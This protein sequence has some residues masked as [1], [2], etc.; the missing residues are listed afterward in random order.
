[1]LSMPLKM[2]IY[3]QNKCTI[4]S[5]YTD[6]SFLSCF[7][8]GFGCAVWHV[9]LGAKSS[10]LC[11]TLYDLMDCSALGSSVK[12]TGVG[13]H[14]PL[15]GIFLNQGSNTHLL[16]WQ[17]GSLPLAPPG[18]PSKAC[19]VLILPPGIE[20]MPPEL[21]V[22]SLNHWTTREVPPQASF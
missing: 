18:K 12:N 16:H 13:C 9:C 14:A 6:K 1:M 22:W 2:C 11:L 20:P 8:F 10:W 4:V 19:R 21:G 17:A 3:K 15:Q 5:Q 7:V